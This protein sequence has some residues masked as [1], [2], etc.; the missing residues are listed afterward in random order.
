LL[1]EGRDGC[2]ALCR[3]VARDRFR[4]GI[5]DLRASDGPFGSARRRGDQDGAVFLNRTYTDRD[6]QLSRETY[7][8][9]VADARHQFV[10]YGEVGAAIGVFH[11]SLRGALYFI[12][13]RCNERGWP[14]LTVWVVRKDS[15]LPGLGCDVVEAGEV[16][17][18]AEAVR[19]ID[20][21]AEPWW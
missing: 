4:P 17:E 19:R 10:T 15:G 6:V 21:P 7:R 18:T 9:L 2:L 20:W 5:S 14:T 1:L 3:D 11:R 8:F 16:R 13:D 12:Q